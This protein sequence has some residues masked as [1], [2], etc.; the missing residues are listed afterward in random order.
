M[1]IL[2]LLYIIYILY[3][4]ILY[5]LCIYHVMAPC[6]LIQA[7]HPL[8]VRHVVPTRS[9]AD[10]GRRKRRSLSFG[11]SGPLAQTHLPRITNSSPTSAPDASRCIQM[12]KHRYVQSFNLTAKVKKK[13]IKGISALYTTSSRGS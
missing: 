6:C 8:M 10:C 7:F 13:G 9:S 3:L 1:Y 11:P 4:Y 5:I 12:R 2:Y